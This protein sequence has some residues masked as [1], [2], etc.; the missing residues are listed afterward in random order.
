MVKIGN[1]IIGDGYPCFITFEA[2]PTHNGLESAMRL[3]KMAKDGGAD[4]IKFQIFKP[5]NLVADRQLMFTYKVLVDKG[6]G[7]TEEISEPLY[8]IFVRRHLADDEWGQ[9][10]LCADSLGLAFFATIG[11]QEGLELVEALGCHSIKVASADINH[12]PFIRRVA[13]TGLC[14]QLDTGNATFGEIEQAVDIILGEGNE[15]IIIHN[16]PSGYPARLESINLR[17]IPALKSTFG[18]PI[19]YSDHTPGWDMDIAALALGANLLEKT[20]SENRCTRSVE[21]IMSLELSEMGRFVQVVRDV[22]IAMGSSRRI[23]STQER[24]NRMNIRRS[25]YL[26][27]SAT[28]GQRLGQIKVSFKRPGFGVEPSRYEELLDYCFCDDMKAGSMVCVH[29]LQPSE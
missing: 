19:A 18:C 9:V 4:A 15:N 16:C 10:K 24:K 6:T 8:D 7:A 22:E 21:H 12:L 25:V 23:L 14:I 1:K 20:I 28:K 27:E 11:D 2:G 13:S 29:H 3:V 17:M 26:E 5:D